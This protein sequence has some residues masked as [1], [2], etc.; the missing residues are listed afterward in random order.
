M[1]DR[2]PITRYGLYSEQNWTKLQVNRKVECPRVGPCTPF[3]S[4]SQG[5]DGVNTYHYFLRFESG[6]AI[7]VD[8]P[9]RIAVYI[10]CET[11]KSY[12]RSSWWLIPRNI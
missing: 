4:T 3:E 8:D 11:L 10:V 1:T 12:P 7:L 2:N 6:Q 9:S 5:S